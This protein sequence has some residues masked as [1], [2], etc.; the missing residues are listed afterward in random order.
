VIYASTTSKPFTLM[1]RRADGSGSAE[2]ILAGD[3]PRFPW[4]YAPGGDALMFGETD[5]ATG[6]DLWVLPTAGGG[7]PR[8]F[9]RSPFEERSAVFSPGGRAV[10][11]VSNESGRDEVYVTAFPGP[12]GKWQVSANGGVMPFW[13]PDGRRLFYSNGDKLM[14]AGVVLGANTAIGVPEMLMSRQ[15]VKWFAAARD[16]RFLTLEDEARRTDLSQ[17]NVVLNWLT[18]V[19]GRL[20]TGS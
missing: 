11:Y 1:R 14:A 5:P 10:A 13:S 19:R 15:R 9:L 6:V 3:R 7:T 2:Q 17:I 4:A 18:T 12:G 20:G 16:G 8:P